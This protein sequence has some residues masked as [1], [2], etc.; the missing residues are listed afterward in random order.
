MIQSTLGYN[1]D[2]KFKFFIPKLDSIYIS[3]SDLTFI[4]DLA[5]IVEKD[6]SLP[7]VSSHQLS[8]YLLMLR[9]LVNKKFEDVF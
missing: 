9:C 5:I 8:T 4:R 7:V 2:P 6:S 1:A 3:L